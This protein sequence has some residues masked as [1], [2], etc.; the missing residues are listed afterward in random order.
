MTS[1]AQPDPT[2]DDAT[3]DALVLRASTARGDGRPRQALEI[4][5]GVLEADP[6]HAGGRLELALALEDFGRTGEARAALSLL[7]RSG[8]DSAEVWARLGDR[9]RDEGRLAAALPCLRRAL[10]LDPTPHR[11]LEL[12][13]LLAARGDFKAS[14]DR[15]REAL[16]A[17][18]DA[19]G[20]AGLAEAL[21]ALGRFDEA[22]EAADRAISLAP[23]LAAA[24]LARHN[25][26]LRRG[27]FAAAWQDADARWGDHPPPQM[28]GQPWDGG[29]CP[30]QT[31][32]LF[33]EG[34]LDD[35]MQALRFVAPAAQASG[36][37]LVLAVPPPLLALL[38]DFPACARVVGLGETLAD[39]LRVDVHAALLDLP[40]LL[41]LAEPP[42]PPRLTARPDHHR[43]VAAPPAA[44]LK[45]GLAWAGERRPQQ[46][47]FPHLMPLLARP[48]AA[49]FSLQT[50]PRA[51][52]A[53]ALAHPCLITDLAPTIGDFADLAAR[54]AEMDL[55]IAADSLAG[56]LG[57]LLGKEV[58]LLL[59]ADSDPRWMAERSDSPWYPGMRLFRQP[60][61]GDWQGAVALA[62]QALDR[63]L[64]QLRHRRDL[65]TARQ[66]RTATVER[67][68]LSA[69]LGPGDLLLD[70][71]SDDGAVSLAAAGLGARVLAVE[72]QPAKAAA[73][74]ASGHSAIEVI[75]CAAGDRPGPAL[76][77]NKPW[78]HGRRVF[79]L[80][81]WR[82]GGVAMR[83]L[84]HL[85]A[86]RPELDDLRLV[87]RIGARGAEGEVLAGLEQSLA[88]ARP[89]IIVFSHRP[90]ESCA[91][92]LREASFRLF[93]L[94]G[95]C[96]VGAP[97]DFADG[98]A[99][100]VLALA[101]GIEPAACYGDA[102]AANARAE[103]NDLAAQ[104]G[105]RQREGDFAESARLCAQALAA[106][107]TNPE[108]NAN[109]GV[110]LRR[111]GAVDAA[112][113][114]HRRALAGSDA[115]ALWSNLGN[116]LREAGRLTEA[117]AAFNTALAGDPDHP[118][119][120]Y[121]L[122]LVARDRGH[123][124]GALALLVRSLAL[125]PEAGRRHDLAL[126]LLKSGGIGPGFAELVHRRRPT[127]SLPSAAPAWAGE[128]QP[129]ATVLVRDEGDAIDTLTL[130]RFLPL[131]ARRGLLVTLECDAELTALLSQLPGLEA[132]VA[133]G[134]PLPECDFQA[135]LPDLPHLLGIGESPLPPMPRLAPPEAPSI[136]RAP[137]IV[138]VGLAWSGR[139]D[140]RFCPL[141]ALL[142]LA[143][144]PGLALI[145]LQ[146]GPAAAE[147][148]ACGAGAYITDAGSACD[149]LAEMATVI[150][151]LDVVVGG[152]TAE[153]ILAAA[154]GKPAWVVLPG[155]GGWIWPEGRETTPWFPTMRRFAQEPEGG[156]SEPIGRLG[157]ALA[158]LAAALRP[159]A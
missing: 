141:D 78:R 131:L 133:R 13:A 146:R 76:V 84:D 18:P 35:T 123:A 43:P 52:D 32:L 66:A 49:C 50:G 136:P 97:L 82:S 122:A 125:K 37:E 118:D 38:A 81:E 20:F 51:Q 11:R 120:L 116:A 109:L 156:W 158:A 135:A 71:G 101:A 63:R 90:G 138:R 64:A 36:A 28:P 137:G 152:D 21:S 100:P 15:S 6:D 22:A 45:V 55:V 85:L 79:A 47:P 140:D 42:P 39:D 77:A 96:G 112:I 14:V 46:L 73:L 3:L 129:G 25:L 144:S 31:L 117:E 34:W 17:G 102:T 61:P 111:A 115:P 92:R 143:E 119:F 54:I 19:A 110:T 5:L 83:P 80:P 127:Y 26:A 67:T 44:L 121:N 2:A 94:P 9:L 74:A 59:A 106:D 134:E 130:I 88:A 27:D 89:A 107:P 75:A 124:H 93:R 69:H 98:I 10:T 113:A 95:D 12:A 8:S 159:R 16:A 87:V 132:V 142:P 154:M 105:D 7:A 139:P 57:A 1:P 30:G 53:V 86:E 147:L 62:A 60:Q 68:L 108:A 91:A 4:L 33:A 153:L 104:A 41:D 128:D 155:A 148:A 48:E 99:G 150:A 157:E 151:G 40:R 65:A 23:D 126:T 58:W 103:A 70:V 149:D 24:R 114:F 72:A 29:P 56:H 145:S